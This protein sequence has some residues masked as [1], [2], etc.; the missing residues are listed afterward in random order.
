MVPKFK[1]INFIFL[2]YNL[3]MF[4]IFSAKLRIFQ[5]TYSIHILKVENLES[6]ANA[7]LYGQ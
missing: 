3:K 5:K 2:V 4:F 7:V 6:Y 1:I